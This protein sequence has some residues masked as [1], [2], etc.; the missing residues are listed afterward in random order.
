MIAEEDW[1]EN[2]VV[3][4]VRKVRGVYSWS[5][6]WKCKFCHISPEIYKHLR[7]DWRECC[8]P[9]EESRR[10]GSV[11]KLQFRRVNCADA[12]SKVHSFLSFLTL[13]YL[14]MLLSNVLSQVFIVKC[15]SKSLLLRLIYNFIYNFMII[16]FEFIYNFVWALWHDWGV[17]T[18]VGHSR[19]V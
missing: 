16:Y 11:R 9:Y 5:Q 19:W 15:Y 3:G 7:L 2:L 6:L 14:T 13:L 4:D 17:T 18:C 8:C 12:I 10:C 1:L